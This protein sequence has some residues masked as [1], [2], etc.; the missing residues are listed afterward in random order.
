MTD[1]PATKK[2]NRYQQIMERIFLWHYKEGDREVAFE[3][4]DYV[5]PVQAKGSRDKLGIVQIE[6][7]FALCADKIPS[8]I[9]RPIAAQFIGDDSIAL[10]EFEEG[11]QGVVI[12]SE[13]HYR[14]VPLII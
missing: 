6:Q 12:T 4:S 2:L 3:R 5:F 10:F 7:D 14:L 11:E 1:L 8:L 13:K 9:C